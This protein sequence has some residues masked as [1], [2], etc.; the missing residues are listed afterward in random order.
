MN[1]TNKIYKSKWLWIVIISITII[2]IF[3]IIYNKN[4]KEEAKA[5]AF[6]EGF[7]SFNEGIQN[8]EGYLDDFSYNY[9]TGEVEYI[10]KT[11]TLEMYNRIKNG[12]TEKEVIS[13]L[14]KGEKLNPKNSNTYMIMWGKSGSVIQITFDKKTNTVI[15]ANQVGLK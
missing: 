1:K 5:K 13:V 6:T 12:M 7:K 10:P 15:Y 4:K 8:S 11:I 3:V 9:N 14:G 2:T